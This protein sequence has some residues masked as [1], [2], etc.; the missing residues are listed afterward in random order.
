[1]ARTSAGQQVGDQI[2]IVGQTGLEGSLDRTGCC[3]MTRASVERWSRS[4]T[5][6]RATS[7]STYGGMP[8]CSSDG[9]P[10]SSCTCLYAIWMG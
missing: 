2:G 4:R 9:G 3:S 7:A 5:V 6:A 10:M 1:M 8:G